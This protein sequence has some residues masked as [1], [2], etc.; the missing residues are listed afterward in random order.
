MGKR[1]VVDYPIDGKRV[2]LRVDFNVPL[3]DGRV[4][5]DTRIRKALPTIEYLLDHGCSV[6]LESL[7]FHPEETANDAGFAAQL[8]ALG[9]VFVNDAFGA[10][11][12]AHAS[13][14]G[15]A[16][17][18]PGVAGLLMNAELRAL[19]GLL[20]DPRHPFLVV[21]G[22]AKVADKVGVVRKMLELADGV[23]I[24][25]AMCFTFLKAQ[26]A[27]TGASRVEDESL[28][29]ARDTLARAES[30]GREIA[31]PVDVVAAPGPHEPGERQVAPAADIPAGLMGLDIGPRTIADFT[32]RI[33]GA[34]TVFWNGPM[35]MF[36]VE[37]FAEGTR[38][39]AEAVA[40][41]ACDSVVGGG[42]T[43]SAVRKFSDEASFTHVSTG[44]GASMEFLEGRTLPGVA[45]LLDE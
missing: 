11:H 23:L 8:G 21:L 5:D 17:V 18:L 41:C 25:G 28:E 19:G 42:D 36:E 35:G 6:V 43:V 10:A 30:A 45:A 7:R 12:R 16:H 24:G 14:E 22:G 9:E 31:L 3:K 20:G 37:E 26:G 44:G 4:E 40:G 13:T 29:V 1:S 33:A 32:A 27:R 34:R 2:F 38:A 39:V 15:I